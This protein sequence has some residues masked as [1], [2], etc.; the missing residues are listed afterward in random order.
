[1]NIA[2]SALSHQLDHKYTAKPVKRVPPIKAFSWPFQLP[3]GQ[4]FAQKKQR[5]ELL[6]LLLKDKAPKKEV[7]GLLDALVEA[8][9]GTPF[10][11]AK[12]GRGPWIVGADKL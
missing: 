1:M 10:A 5:D 12:L 7:D 8:S 11:P 4:P 2:R 6:A 9:A 3:F